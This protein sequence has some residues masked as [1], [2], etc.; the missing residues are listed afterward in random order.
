PAAAVV[1]EQ[2]IQLGTGEIGEA[3]AQG[4]HAEAGAN[5]V[6]QVDE[7]LLLR[8]IRRL[9]RPAEQV[10]RWIFIVELTPRPYRGFVDRQALR[11]F[12]VAVTTLDQ[13]MGEFDRALSDLAFQVAT[14]LLAS[15]AQPTTGWTG[16]EFQELLQDAHMHIR[17]GRL[18][19]FRLR[20]DECFLVRQL[21]VGQRDFCIFT[22]RRR[23]FF[24][25][26]VAVSRS[27]LARV[28]TC[29]NTRA[30]SSRTWA[31]C[32]ASSSSS[33]RCCGMRIG[34]DSESPARLGR[35]A[36]FEAMAVR[37]ACMAAWRS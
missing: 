36:G 13:T 31:S 27:P 1:L 9:Q 14:W 34:S 23:I 16:S 25:T 15:R 11:D 20:P 37:A 24:P 21:W 12:P 19:G 35:P 2:V 18:R 29:G 32:N 10:D 17:L 4:R 7:G 33:I 3:R 22:R 28:R 6:Q 26:R 5:V 30:I 8:R